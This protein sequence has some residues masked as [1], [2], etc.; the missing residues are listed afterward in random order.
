M[1]D[2]RVQ[3]ASG[4]RIGWRDLPVS[5]HAAV[6]RILGDAVVEARSQVAGFSPGT[7]DR[8]RTRSGRQAF[9]KA[10]TAA[11]NEQTVQLHRREVAVAAA[12]PAEV[13]A[14]RLLGAHDDGQWVA[15][16]YEDIEGRHPATPWTE[17]ELAAALAA[18]DRLAAVDVPPVLRRVL[19]ATGADLAYDLAGWQRLAADPPAGLDPWAREHLDRLCELADPAPA[20]LAGDRLV[21]TDVRAD[22]LLVRPDGRM[23]LIDWPWASLGPP[24]FDTLCLLINARLYGRTDVD[25]LLAIHTA[26]DP[27][28]LTAVLA[29]VAGY[30]LDAARQPPPKGLPTVRAFQAAQGEAVLAWLRERIERGARSKPS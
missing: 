28:R 12:L 17:A 2:Y 5:V 23:I 8:I 14:P 13:P 4:V 9:V 20:A 26:A 25:A 30:F 18:L 19:P 24:W 1:N 7:A 6:E 22:N 27:G 3:S 29:A 10:A 16:V 11:L 21:H 15:L